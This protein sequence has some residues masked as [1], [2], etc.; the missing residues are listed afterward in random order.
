LPAPCRKKPWVLRNSGFFCWAEPL[1]LALH[2][3]SP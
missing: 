2:G 3:S 1:S